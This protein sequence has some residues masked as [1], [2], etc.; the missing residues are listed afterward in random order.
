MYDRAGL[1]EWHLSAN[2]QGESGWTYDATQDVATQRVFVSQPKVGQHRCLVLCDGVAVD[3]N[4]SSSSLDERKESPL[5]EPSNR[6]RFVRMRKVYRWSSYEFF[7]LPAKEL[8][9]GT[10]GIEPDSLWDE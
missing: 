9:D 10:R 5:V 3:H 8:G 2:V 4:V 7:R 1:I 6:G